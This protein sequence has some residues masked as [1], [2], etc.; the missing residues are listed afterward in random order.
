L[1]ASGSRTALPRHQTLRAS[2]DWSYGLLSEPE[3]CLL[4][5]L[6][7]FAGG[8]TLE[9]A[10]AVCSDDGTGL[11]APASC[12]HAGAQA[13]KTPALPGGSVLIREEAVLGLLTALVDKSL[14]LYEDQQG[15]G[16]YR[17]LESVRQYGRE[18]LR[19]AGEEEALRMAHFSHFLALAERAEPEV[20]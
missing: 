20:E 19:E 5:R 7:V 11:G 17:L 10:E 4:R 13:G 18:R 15:G 16:R 9:A 2:M 14:V 1:L 3:R 12:R 6:S 8:W